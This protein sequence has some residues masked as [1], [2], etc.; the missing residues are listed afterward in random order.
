MHQ[1]D[2]QSLHTR[3][4]PRIHRLA[5]ALTL[6]TPHPL[7]ISGRGGSFKTTLQGSG[8][9]ASPS[10]GN[11]LTKLPTA[12]TSDAAA[13]RAHVPWLTIGRML[14]H[15]RSTPRAGIRRGETSRPWR[16]QS[17]AGSEGG[18]KADTVMSCKDI[19]AA[20]M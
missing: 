13:R 8:V 16:E 7:P 18:V 19:A 2:T 1:P 17:G 10:F 11:A 5:L 3:G 9:T 20:E 12:L 4:M 14:R 6:H 15:D